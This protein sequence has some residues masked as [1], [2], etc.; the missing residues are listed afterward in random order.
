MLRWLEYLCG[1]ATVSQIHDY[2]KTVAIRR[3]HP[4]TPYRIITV[5]KE[6]RYD[7]MS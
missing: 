1:N 2:A 7:I 5:K 4:F 3:M 6:P